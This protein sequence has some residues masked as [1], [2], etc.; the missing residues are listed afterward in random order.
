MS[1][2]LQPGLPRRLVTATFPVGAAIVTAV[3]TTVMANRLTLAATASLLLA[4]A[5][6]TCSAASSP[7][8]SS[9]PAIL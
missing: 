4:F 3:V 1:V 6:G 5:L 2:A 7:T 9:P 8:A